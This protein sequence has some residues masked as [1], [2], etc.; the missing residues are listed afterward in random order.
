MR[1]EKGFSMRYT[2]KDLLRDLRGCNGHNFSGVGSYTLHFVANDGET[3]H[4]VC[5]KAHVGR[6][7]RKIRD[8]ERDAILG[9]DVYWEGPAEQC[10]ECGED[11]ESSYGDPDKTGIEVG[12]EEQ[13]NGF[14]DVGDYV[15]DDATLYRV[16]SLGRAHAPSTAGRANWVLATVTPANWA[17]CAEADEHTARVVTDVDSLLPS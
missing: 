7:A 17:D 1:P 11:I 14:P 5:V 3:F 2:V 12:I 6:E 15:R 9:L 8:G 10:G 16:V 13:G 4:P